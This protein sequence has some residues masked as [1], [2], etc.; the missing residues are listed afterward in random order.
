MPK[1]YSQKPPSKIESAEQQAQRRS[2]KQRRPCDQP[3]SYKLRVKIS[4]DNSPANISNSGCRLIPLLGDQEDCIRF[5]CQDELA[6]LLRRRFA[7]GDGLIG[8]GRRMRTRCPCGQATRTSPGGCARPVRG[9]H[10]CD[11]CPDAPLRLLEEAAL[12][13]R[14]PHA[15]AWHVRQRCCPLNDETRCNWVNEASRLL[16]G[17]SSSVPSTCRHHQSEIWRLPFSSSQTCSAAPDRCGASAS[18]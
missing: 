14:L 3:A 18:Q 2:R 17:T 15:Q 11:R 1:R 4:S 7:G 13:C 10:A 12:R 8:D 9:C 16:S 6:G 5:A